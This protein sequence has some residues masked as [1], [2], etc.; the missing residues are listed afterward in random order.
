MKNKKGFTLIEL[1]VV[2]SVIAILSAV[3]VAA[4]S[5][6]SKKGR[7][8]RRKADMKAFQNAMEQYYEANSYSYGTDTD[9]STQ[10]SAHIQGALPTDPKTGGY[11]YACTATTYC[12]CAAMEDTTKGNSTSNACA[13]ASTG[14]YFC[15]KNLQ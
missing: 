6:T 4:Y 7:D 1:L 3:G 9:C 15:V 13:F 10:L 12:I 14:G 5:S 8:T 2:V 11:N